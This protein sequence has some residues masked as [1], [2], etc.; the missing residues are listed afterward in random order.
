MVGVWHGSVIGKR[1]K[2]GRLGKEMEKE[3]FG[4][5]E[6]EAEELKYRRV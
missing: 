1:K 3:G 5:R 4:K 2:S 6:R